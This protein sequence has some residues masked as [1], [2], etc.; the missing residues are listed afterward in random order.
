M[1]AP[2]SLSEEVFTIQSFNKIEYLVQLSIESESLNIKANMINQI[3]SSIYHKIYSF[4]EIIKLNKYFKMCES[5]SD[6]FLELKNIIKTNIKNIKINDNSE[7]LVITFPLPSFLVTEINFRIEKTTKNEKEQIG[8]LYKSI[9]I[10]FEKIKKLEEKNNNVNEIKK[11]ENKIDELEKENNIFKSE[12]KK[13]NEYLFP[14]SIFNSKISFDEKIIKEWINKKFTANLLFRLTKNGSEPSEFH[15]LCDNKG[16]TIIFI[17]TTKGYK[18]GGYTEL[19]W[20]E[21]SSFKTDNSTFLF[22]INNKA[23]YT[24]RNSQYCSIYCR[25]DLAPSFGGDLNPDIFCMGSCKKGQLCKTNTFAT[26]NELNNGEG[27]FD[28]KEMEVYQIKLI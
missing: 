16:P 8:D 27:Y 1:S 4:D 9:Q 19:E 13:I 15:R 28:V 6:I 12:I 24:K 3:T 5:I 2:P 14:E 17:E 7:P 22:S 26:P 18:F 20:D 11:L 10:L 21:S 23:K 25:K